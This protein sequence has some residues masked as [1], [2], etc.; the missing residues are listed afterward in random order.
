MKD[1]DKSREQLLEE[2]TKLRSQVTDM[3]DRLQAL[4]QADRKTQQQV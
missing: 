2:L 3:R 4:E 1:E